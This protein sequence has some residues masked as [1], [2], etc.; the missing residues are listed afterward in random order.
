MLE[1]WER[2]YR[3]FFFSL[4]VV[5]AGLVLWKMVPELW[6]LLVNGGWRPRVSLAFLMIYYVTLRLFA[7][8]ARFHVLEK[9]WHTKS[10]LHV[11]CLTCFFSYFRWQ[12]LYT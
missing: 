7:R 12:L 5:V 11:I 1:R 2:V 4:L 10:L 3:V 9:C 8:T 6:E